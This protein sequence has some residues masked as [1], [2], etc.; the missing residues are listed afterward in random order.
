MLPENVTSVVPGSKVSLLWCGCLDLVLSSSPGVTR[1]PLCVCHQGVSEQ[2]VYRLLSAL[3]ASSGKKTFVV[4]VHVSMHFCM[5]VH[6]SGCVRICGCV[7]MCGLL[8]ESI[9]PW[10]RHVISTWTIG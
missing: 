1:E 4:Y 3:A 9:T 7:F 8:Y 10:A 6:V 2:T 5:S